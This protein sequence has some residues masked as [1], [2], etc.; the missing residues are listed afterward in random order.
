LVDRRLSITGLATAG[1]S[2]ASRPAVIAPRRGQV[3]QATIGDEAKYHDGACF[4]VDGALAECDVR[5]CSAAQ[6]RSSAMR[7]PTTST[8]ARFD[9]YGYDALT[10]TV[11]RARGQQVGQIRLGFRSADGVVCA[12]PTGVDQLGG[13]GMEMRDQVGLSGVAVKSKRTALRPT[14]TR[15]A[16]VEP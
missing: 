1:S 11:C 15:L 14:A 4:A 12:R 2:A 3:I 10:L 8:I 13:T 16:E 5:R 6:V 9:E 7:T